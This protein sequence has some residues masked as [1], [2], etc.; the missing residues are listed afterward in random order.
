[1]RRF[2]STAICGGDWSVAGHDRCDR[3]AGT[4][5]EHIA[6]RVTPP[7][8]YER[9]DRRCLKHPPIRHAG[10]LDAAFGPCEQ[11]LA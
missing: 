7:R 10:W 3:A 11:G 8:F 9:L 5:D 2:S 4:H 1:M 6:V